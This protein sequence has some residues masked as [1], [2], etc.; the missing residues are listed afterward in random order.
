MILHLPFVNISQIKIKLKLYPDSLLLKCISRNLIVETY[1]PGNFCWQ[2][3]S[4][5]IVSEYLYKMYFL[6]IAKF[7][8]K[9]NLLLVCL[10]IK[11]GD[12]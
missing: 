3:N 10:E 11:G 9:Q 5:L 7:S 12:L 4:T 2:I 1:R 6:Y 8:R